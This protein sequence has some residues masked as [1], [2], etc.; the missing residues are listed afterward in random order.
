MGRASTTR[1]KRRA[2]RQASASAPPTRDRLPRHWRQNLPI[3]RFVVLFVALLG[4]FQIVYHEWV[5]SS[6]AFSAYLT[7]SSRMAATLLHLVGEPVVAIG[8]TLLSGFSMSIKRG[9]DGLQV[10]AILVIAVLVFPGVGFKKL[11]GICVGVGLLLVLNV[12]R[13]ATLFWAGVHLS[14][15]F[16]SLHVHVWP[17]FL[18]LA[19]VIFWLGWATWATRPGAAG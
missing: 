12:V 19:A 13:I 10:I 18:I 7:I 11:I 14:D 2:E 8:D 5:V 1:R 9:C 15:Q 6:E 17:A 3:I 4:V 16:Q